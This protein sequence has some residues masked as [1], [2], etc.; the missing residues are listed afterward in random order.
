[1][2]DPASSEIWLDYADRSYVTARLLWFMG[3]WIECPVNGHRAIELFLKA[4]LVSKGENVER[5]DR[6]WGHKLREL[7]KVCEGY[8]AQFGDSAVSRRLE[9]FE[10]YFD[11]V[12]YPSD[13][14]SPS[15]GSLVWF[16]F[17]ANVL[18]LDELVAFI[19]PRIET[20]DRAWRKSYLCELAHGEQSKNSYQ[21]RALEDSNGLL[22]QIVCTETN[23]TV[24]PFSMD[25]RYDLP[26]C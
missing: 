16:S 11:F 17:D 21:K 12:R 18:P 4:Y 5:G 7:G 22:S 2:F 3:F 9:F 10:R 23:E 24:V 13:P 14:G 19:R 6:A 8:S 20:D 26:G 1:M 25:F 15:D